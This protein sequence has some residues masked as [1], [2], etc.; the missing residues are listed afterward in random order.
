LGYIS[1]ADH[2][3][4]TDLKSYQI[5]SNNTNK[6]YYAVQ[7]HSRIPNFSISQTYMQLPISD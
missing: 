2:L 1:D 5:R 3:D 6:G 4:I 7:D